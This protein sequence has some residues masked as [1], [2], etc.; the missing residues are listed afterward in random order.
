MASTACVLYCHVV[1]TSASSSVVAWFCLLF[2]STPEAATMKATA[3]TTQASSSRRMT[4][5]Q[6]TYTRWKRNDDTTP[7]AGST[8]HYCSAPSPSTRTGST[9]AAAQTPR[10]QVS[11][12]CS[13]RDRL[14]TTPLMRPGHGVWL[15]MGSPTIGTSKLNSYTIIWLA[16]SYS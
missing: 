13:R 12:A 9:S 16:Q 6:E 2:S 10:W 3:T 1:A 14:Q 4:T 11:I 15:H 5:M 8:N 7:T